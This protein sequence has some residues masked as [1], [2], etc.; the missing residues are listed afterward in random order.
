MTN[1]VSLSHRKFLGLN[2]KISSAFFPMFNHSKKPKWPLRVLFH[3]VGE[4]LQLPKSRAIWRER[5]NEL[6]VAEK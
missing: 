2:I 3:K 4:I 1:T 5:F 6:P